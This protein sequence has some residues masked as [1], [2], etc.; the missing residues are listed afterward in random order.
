MQGGLAEMKRIGKYTV[1]GLLGRGGM[2]RVYKVEIPAIGLVLA[3]KRLEP[4]PYLTTLLGRDRVRALFV[5]EARTMVRLRHPHVVD[6]FDFEDAA[7]APFYTMAFYGHDLGTTIGETFRTES[8]SRIIA[9]EKAID[10][11]D[12]VL[13]GLARL[14][15]AGIVHRDI[16]PFNVLIT[17]QDTIKI[18]DFGLSKLRGES[19]PTPGNLKIGT[20][21]YAAPEQ[22]AEPDRV[23]ARADLYSVGMM[24]FRMVTGTL[25]GLSKTPGG[26]IRADLGTDWAVFFERALARQP[27]DRFENGDAMRRALD[28][29]GKKWRDDRDRACMLVPSPPAPAGPSALN[30]PVRTRPLKVLDADTAKRIFGLDSLWRPIR[31]ADPGMFHPEAGGI[32]RGP[33]GRVWQWSGSAYP[34]TFS[35]AKR[36]VAELNV[37]G[38]AG[39]NDWRLPTIDELLGILTPPETG[40]HLCIDP[41]FDQRQRWLWSADRRSFT[42]AW[43]VSLP[44]GFVAW[45]DFNG[46]N[47]VKAVCGGPLSDG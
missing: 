26:R 5:E 25:P 1:C 7:D 33:S 34:M 17:E 10:Y 35:D 14:H 24:L 37:R 19:V 28:R 11:T 27:G 41:V 9:V 20:P 6:V 23:D 44:L 39:R 40:E 13:S 38:L 16:K 15:E 30:S 36:A 45:Q 46:L 4:N 31:Y 18:C 8:A 12:Q 47:Y 32:V 21:Y 29:L 42:S 22:E 3:L 2:G 43:Y